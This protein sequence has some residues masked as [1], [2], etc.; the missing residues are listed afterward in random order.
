MVKLSV[1]LIANAC[2]YTNAI[3]DRELDLRGYKIPLIENLGATLNHFDTIDFSDNELRKVDNFP[4]L[5]RLKTLLLNNNRICRIGESLEEC[6]PALDTVV[7]TNNN[8]QDLA[9]IEAL[10]SVKTISM[11]SFLHNPVVSKPNYRAFV[12][13]KFPN[14]RV[15]DFK[16]V[17]YHEQK[18]AKA[19]FKTSE[20]KAQLKEIKK[21]AKTFTPGEAINGSAG[22]ASNGVNASGLSADQVRSIKT[23]IAKATTLEE[24]E[25]LN[26]MLRTGII[27]G[28]EPETQPAPSKKSGDQIEEM[29]DD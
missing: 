18:E 23:A 7:F 24:I 12:I 11:L 20:G 21:R 6:L 17:K 10:S 4:L 28:Q 9:D 29:D 16:R 26:Q 19:L 1:D 13:H 27:P 25:R 22:G 5:P 2:Q 14:L 3:R 15:L 8:I